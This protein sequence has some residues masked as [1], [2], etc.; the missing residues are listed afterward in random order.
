MT[1]LERKVILVLCSFFL[2]VCLTAAVLFMVRPKLGRA[3]L[4]GADRPAAPGPPH[5]AVADHDPQ[6][7][8]GVLSRQRVTGE[9]T[10]P[11][12]RHA[13]ATIASR[14]VTRHP[15]DVP[16]HPDSPGPLE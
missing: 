5:V 13:M 11:Q 8:E 1:R 2:L 10:R 7:L 12:Y 3:V 16:P 15:L 9:I 6:T 14:D 4:D